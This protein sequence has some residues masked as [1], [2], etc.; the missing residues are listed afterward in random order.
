MSGYRKSDYGLIRHT[1]DAISKMDIDELECFEGFVEEQVEKRRKQL[2]IR[3]TVKDAWDE[4]AQLKRI[5]SVYFSLWMS[6]FEN[7][8]NG[9]AS[10]AHFIGL[11]TTRIPIPLYKFVYSTNE[12]FA[13]EEDESLVLVSTCGD[14]VECIKLAVS[15]FAKNQ[16][17]RWPRVFDGS[18]D[19]YVMGAP[20]GLAHQ[21]DSN[22]PDILPLH[23]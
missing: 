13:I 22:P 1:R 8:P 16:R 23:S 19:P 11:I 10:G 12:L 9:S 5:D 2:T 7:L 3:P 6:S 21:G 14:V 4:L 15:D 20:F 18:V 17:A